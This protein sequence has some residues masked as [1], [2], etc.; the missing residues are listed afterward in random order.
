MQ[1]KVAPIEP[2]VYILGMSFLDSVNPLIRW[3]ERRM[4][5]PVRKTE[6]QNYQWMTS[7]TLI[8]KA[9][10]GLTSSEGWEERTSGAI[11]SDDEDED[12]VQST[13]A[14]TDVGR[15]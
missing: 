6:G 7:L 3:K 12:D 2:G 4:R 14:I 10:A 8:A 13:G 15:I 9:L 11:E 1:F 5:L